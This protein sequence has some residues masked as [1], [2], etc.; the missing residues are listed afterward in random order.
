MLLSLFAAHQAGFSIAVLDCLLQVFKTIHD[1]RMAQYIQYLLGSTVEYL[2]RAIGSFEGASGSQY[3]V[4][5]KLLA[6]IETLYKQLD[7][8]VDTDPELIEE[9]VKPE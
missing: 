4:I 9:S 7:Y 2:E 3:F 5:N 6:F 8:A 1:D